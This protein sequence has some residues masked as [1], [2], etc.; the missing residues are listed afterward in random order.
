MFAPPNV[1]KWVRIEAQNWRIGIDPLNVLSEFSVN[2]WF[3]S[4]LVMC[5][6]SFLDCQIVFVCVIEYISTKDMVECRCPQCPKI[7]KYGF[8]DTVTQNGFFR[9]LDCFE[10]CK[11]FS[12]RQKRE[13]ES[14]GM[15]VLSILRLLCLF[16]L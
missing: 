9:H 7:T 14:P 1:T 2:C 10:V 16:S 11:T 3:S 15:R 12:S 5:L 8:L 4:H 6:V 13:R